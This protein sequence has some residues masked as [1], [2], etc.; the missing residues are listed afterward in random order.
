MREL[1][2]VTAPPLVQAAA[3]EAAGQWV[4]EPALLHGEPFEV[5]S[6]IEVFFTLKP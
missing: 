5:E 6:T 2:F 1:Q 3:R 4:H